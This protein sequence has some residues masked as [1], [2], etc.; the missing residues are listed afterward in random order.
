MVQK[1]LQAIVNA[2]G[3]PAELDS[4]TILLKTLCTSTWRN[5]AGTQLEASSP[6]LIVHS[7]GR[8]YVRCPM[9]KVISISL[10]H[11]PHKP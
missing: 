1:T 5:L 4:K 9:R 10:R 7:A 6:L 2:I 8:C 11:E 3:Y